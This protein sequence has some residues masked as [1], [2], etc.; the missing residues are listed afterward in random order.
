MESLFAYDIKSHRGGVLERAHDRTIEAVACSPD[1]SRL[2]SSD[3]VLDPRDV[4]VGSRISVWSFEKLCSQDSAHD[5]CAVVLLTIHVDQAPAASEMCSDAAR[6][7]ILYVDGVLELR[8]VPEGVLLTQGK[9]HG[10]GKEK[11]CSP[12]GRYA[13]I[14]ARDRPCAYVLDAKTGDKWSVYTDGYL[15]GR[16]EPLTH[17]AFARS[18][19]GQEADVVE[20]LCG[21]DEYAIWDLETRERL[22]DGHLDAIGIEK[23]VPEY[24]GVLQLARISAPSEYHTPSS[25]PFVRFEV[26]CESAGVVEVGWHHVRPITAVAASAAGLFAFGDAEGRVVVLRL[27]ERTSSPL[28]VVGRDG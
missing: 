1:G 28:A 24:N 21:T 5:P 13:V 26:S 3:D 25:D 23:C 9:L 14:A 7:L 27:R 15:D 22:P 18:V 17:I 11:T 8:T 4:A 12:N 2:V 19:I 10:V 20:L 16:E 6:V